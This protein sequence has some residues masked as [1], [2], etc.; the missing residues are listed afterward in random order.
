MYYIKIKQKSG[1][2]TI[3]RTIYIAETI[4]DAFDYVY[5][6]GNSGTVYYIYDSSYD[7]IKV[8]ERLWFICIIQ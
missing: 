7:I 6:R 3:R 2:Y 4:D 5:R 1:S 8:V